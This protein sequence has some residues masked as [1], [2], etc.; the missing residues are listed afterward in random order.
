[1]II[2]AFAVADV[3][4]DDTA[5]LGS[6]FA[7]DLYRHLASMRMLLA[8]SAYSLHAADNPAPAF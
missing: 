5:R 7:V 3:A 4:A 8:M 2:C 1:V 6:Y